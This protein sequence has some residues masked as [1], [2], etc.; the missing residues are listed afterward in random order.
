LP[1]QPIKVEKS[2]FFLDQ[3]TL[4][5]CHLET[6]CNIAIVIPKRCNGMNFSALCPI[7]V[8]FGPETYEFTLLTIAPFFGDTVKNGIARKISQN[9][10]DLS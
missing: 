8:A 4:S 7:L 9:F 5:R 1:W 6:D 2:A 3:S 10:P